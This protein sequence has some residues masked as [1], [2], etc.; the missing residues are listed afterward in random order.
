MRT[1]LELDDDLVQ[2]LQARHP[3][4]SKTEAIQ[5][6]VRSYLAEDARSRL[7]RVAGSLDIE[8][9]SAEMRAADRRT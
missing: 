6:A 3:G 4:V 9:L 5:I 2:A 8:D 7:R 1:T